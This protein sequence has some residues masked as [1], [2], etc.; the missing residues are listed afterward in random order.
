ML[1][2]HVYVCQI[3][4]DYLP[5]FEPWPPSRARHIPWAPD[6]HTRW[7]ALDGGGRRNTPCSPK[8]LV[9]PLLHLLRRIHLRP[10]RTSTPP[11]PSD[12]VVIPPVLLLLKEAQVTHVLRCCGRA[13]LRAAASELLFKVQTKCAYG[14]PGEKTV[15]NFGI[16]AVKSNNEIGPWTAVYRSATE[17]AM[18]PTSAH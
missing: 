4:V 14:G 16:A 15:V 5:S 9:V 6:R 12:I 17:Y 13:V 8:G 10:Y 1:L 18:T 3:R 2:F 7:F 11:A